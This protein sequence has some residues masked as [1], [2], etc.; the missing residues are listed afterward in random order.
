MKKFTFNYRYGVDLPCG[1][2]TITVYADSELEAKVTAINTLRDQRR[3]FGYWL[4][5]VK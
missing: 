4:E 3:Y 1:R 2:D 5:I